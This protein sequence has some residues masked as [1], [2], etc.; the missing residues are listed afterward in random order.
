MLTQ[1]P[2]LTIMVTSFTEVR[3]YPKYELRQ[4]HSWAAQGKVL[5]T[6]SVQ[7]DATNLGYGLD[8][9]CR[10]LQ[11]LR[12]SDFRHSGRYDGALWYDVYRVRFTSPAGY[13]DDLYIKLALG[14][15]C[16][17][18]NLFSFHLTRAI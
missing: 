9:I 6:S 11:E 18:I 12:S 1:E 10:C 13:L 17:V 8:D 5:V 7:R 3:D 4:V 14:Q 16:L 15:D 2:E